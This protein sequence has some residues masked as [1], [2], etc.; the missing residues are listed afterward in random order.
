MKKKRKR[1]GH[2]Q[3]TVWQRGGNWWIQWREGGRRKSARYTD[4]STARRVLKRILGDLAAGR[5]G[6]EIEKAPAPPLAELAE[7]W[8]A[9]RDKTHR[10]AKE[11]RWRWKKHMATRFGHLRPDEVDTGMLRRFIEALLASGLSSSTAHLCI[12]ELSALFSDLVEQGHVQV[13][14]VRLL[15]RATRR[16][17]RPA[18]D[19]RTTPFVERLEDVRRI[20][21]AL[22]E[23]ICL[24]YAL[25]AL[26]GLR[27]GEALALRWAHVDM[28]A[29]R[30]H[31]RESIKGPLK[32]IDS[33]IVPIQDAL[34]PL[35]AEWRLRCGGIGRVVPSMRS[36]GA[37]LDSHTIRAHL[38]TTITKLELPALTWYEATRHT[39]ASQWVLGGNSLEKLREVMG[40]STVQVTERYA[41]LKPELFGAADRAT[42]KVSLARGGGQAEAL[43]NAVATLAG[44][45][46]KVTG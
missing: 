29:R 14:P 2:G 4:E 23:P 26:A 10:S 38:K 1:A 44:D 13:N 34:Y 21:L 32:D 31:V 30:I 17:I 41:H 5:G 7:G 18:H 45:G 27:N 9:R 11:D 22:P 16:L 46:Q 24:A 42:L 6:L 19:P 39:F 43:G 3:G 15:P 28:N 8:L 36:D 35:L 40:H 37:F 12:A 20:F 33:R 25:G